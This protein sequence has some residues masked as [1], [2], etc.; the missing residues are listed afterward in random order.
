MNP[1]LETRCVIASSASLP[2]GTHPLGEANGLRWG[3]VD[4]AALARTLARGGKDLSLLYLTETAYRE[5]VS[6]KY[7]S[8]KSLPSLACV[9]ANRATTTLPPRRPLASPSGGVPLGKDPN[10]DMNK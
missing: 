4:A 1:D 3:S 5:A 2:S 8:D 7:K 10:D 9:R 6:V